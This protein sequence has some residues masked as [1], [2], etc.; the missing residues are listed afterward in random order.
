MS[1]M[2]HDIFSHFPSKNLLVSVLNNY[3]NNILL[4]TTD[5]MNLH[6]KIYSENERAMIDH[7][8]NITKKRI[9]SPVLW[10]P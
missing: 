1:L 6:N 8:G 5:N 7:E 2:L 9:V 10:M 3:D 4:L